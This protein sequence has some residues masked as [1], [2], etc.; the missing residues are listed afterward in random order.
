VL[1]VVSLIMLVALRFIE[2]WGNRHD[3]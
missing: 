2:Y 1:L 3:H